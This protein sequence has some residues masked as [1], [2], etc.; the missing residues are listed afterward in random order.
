MVGVATDELDAG[1]VADDEDD[2]I[3]MDDSDDSDDN[4]DDA[5]ADD[6]LL[7]FTVC[8][9]FSELELFRRSENSE[10]ITVRERKKGRR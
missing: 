8:G 4:D 1:V 3:G 2:D 7:L 5:G 10:F 6:R 9:Y